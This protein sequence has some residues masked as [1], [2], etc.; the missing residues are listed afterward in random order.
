MP[1][2]FGL[3]IF[4]T[5]TVSL[6]HKESSGTKLFS[7]CGCCCYDGGTILVVWFCLVLKITTYICNILTGN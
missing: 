3:L 1:Y 2:L 6:M 7:H 4:S 5:T